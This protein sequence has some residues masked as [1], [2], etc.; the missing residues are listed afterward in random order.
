[1]DDRPRNGAIT[2]PIWRQGPH[3][4]HRAREFVELVVWLRT[5]A[6]GG[7]LEIAAQLLYGTISG[8]EF[9]TRSAR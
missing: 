7:R 6:R 4:S 8:T 3:V 2:A 5:L 1:M 9:R